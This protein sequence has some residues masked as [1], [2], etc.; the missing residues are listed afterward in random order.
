MKTFLSK[1]FFFIIVITL[2]TISS[3]YALVFSDVASDHKNYDAIVSMSEKKIVNGY[4]DGS[5][6]PDNSVTR[7]ELC[8]IIARAAGYV[9]N[10]GDYKTDLPFSDVKS[11]YWAED[12]IK[13]AFENGIVNGMGD[14]TFLPAGGGRYAPALPPCPPPS[15]GRSTDPPPLRLRPGWQALP[16]RWSAPAPDRWPPCVGR[17]Q[18]RNRRRFPHIPACRLSLPAM[19]GHYAGRR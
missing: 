6:K 12:Y 11:G 19:Q 13:F 2:F 3:G 4:D 9:K 14:G 16:P 17:R 18:R 10:S 1:V 5:F 7:A 8:V 15:S